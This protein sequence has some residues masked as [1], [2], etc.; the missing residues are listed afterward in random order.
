MTATDPTADLVATVSDTPTA[1][2]PA[3]P[4]QEP[5]LAEVPVRLRWIGADGTP[6]LVAGVLYLA[7][8][9]SDRVRVTPF[10]PRVLATKFPAPA[11]DAQPG[12][13]WVDVHIA[14]HTATWGGEIA[15]EWLGA[16]DLLDPERI[17]PQTLNVR[18][19]IWYG[20]QMRR[21]AGRPAIQ[22]EDLASAAP[23]V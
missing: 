16:V 13:R 4:E 23:G 11:P 2:D 19:I 7:V 3:V 9:E 21:K 17:T 6:D 12:D 8:R 5:L 20:E 22:V 1:T 10:L 15:A 14:E 18:W